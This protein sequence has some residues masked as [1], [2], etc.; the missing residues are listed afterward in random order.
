MSKGKL[1]DS[2][3]A[4]VI[5]PKTDK[6]PAS[7]VYVYTGDSDYNLLGQETTKVKK[8]MEGYN[9]IVLLK[10]NELPDKFDLS[11]TDEK[12]ADKIDTPTRANFFKYIID[13]AKEGYYLD[14]WIWSHGWRDEK[15]RCSKGT[16]GNND[17]IKSSDISKELS[18]TNSKL[19]CIPIRMVYQ[20]NCWGSN[21]NA[22]W[23]GAGAKVSIGTKFLDFYPT[24]YGNFADEW[25]KNS[26]KIKDA[27]EK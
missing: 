20:I 11:K 27:V 22:S 14:I 15:F 18:S 17:Y 26:V 2:T 12:L 3:T 21:L 16:Y 5:K 13:L 9:K 10:H 23:I 4:G 7:L 1:I 19:T 24:Q 25:N 6:G 8:A